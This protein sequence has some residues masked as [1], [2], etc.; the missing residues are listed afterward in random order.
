M[1]GGGVD[2]SVLMNTRID[3][4]KSCWRRVVGISTQVG[5]NVWSGFI[6]R[7]A[8]AICTTERRELIRFQHVVGTCG[9]LSIY[10][11]NMIFYSS[12]D[13]YYYHYY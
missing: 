6:S 8:V 4:V 2:R 11:Y 5:Y 10:R 1:L 9:I 12:S 13:Y 3:R 7:D